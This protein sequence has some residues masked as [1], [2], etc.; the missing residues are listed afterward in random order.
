MNIETYH[1]VKNRVI[2]LHL[3]S[4][5]DTS[6]VLDKLLKMNDEGESKVS[7]YLFIKLF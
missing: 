1:D 2:Y 7:E 3:E 5:Y 6:N 4:I